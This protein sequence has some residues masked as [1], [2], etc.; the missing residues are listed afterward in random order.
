VPGGIERGFRNA[1]SEMVAWLTSD[2]GLSPQEAHVI[3]GMAAELRVA[4]WFGTFACQVP[5]KY[6]PPRTGPQPFLR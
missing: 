5:K 1:I 2:Y 3:I 4:S 6:L